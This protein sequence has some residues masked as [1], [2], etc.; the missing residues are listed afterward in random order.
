MP[1]LDPA[2]TTTIGAF[3]PR[4]PIPPA[5]RSFGRYPNSDDWKPG[6]VI[7][8][9]DVT[10]DFSGRMIRKVQS[11]NG[12]HQQHACWEHA[13]LYLGH[14]QVC[15]AV[16]PKVRV[17]SLGEIILGKRLLVRRRDGLSDDQRFAIAI[18]G[19]A[20]TGSWYGW[21]DILRL[22]LA[23]ASM[24]RLRGEVPQRIATRICS[25]H[26]ADAY[27]ASIGVVLATAAGLQRATTPADLAMTAQLQDVSLCWR[28]LPP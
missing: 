18:H 28:S 12:F 20:K 10:P 14:D 25:Q 21:P 16:W 15:E 23:R 26:C 27:A 11:A 22:G 8:F 2:D 3:V 7:L 24:W 6:D 17:V 13:A 19:A 5:V 1:P 9:S 4:G